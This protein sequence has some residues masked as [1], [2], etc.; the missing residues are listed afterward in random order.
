VALKGLAALGCG[1]V[2]DMPDQAFFTS[3]KFL[4]IFIG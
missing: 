4:E 2:E 1:H 3:K